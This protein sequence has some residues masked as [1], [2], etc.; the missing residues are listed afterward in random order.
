MTRHILIDN[1]GELHVTI[2]DW[3]AAVRPHAPGRVAI[4]TLGA[5][6]EW[7]GWVNDDSHPLGLPRNLVGGL[8]LTGLGAAVM[9]YAGPVIITGWTTHGTPTEVCD[10]TEAQIA[11]ILDCHTDARAA[12]AGEPGQLYD[13]AR[14]VAEQMRTAP[15][16]TITLLSG[17]EFFAQ[18][19]GQS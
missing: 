16:P 9:P 4:P 8:V 5:L 1:D 2:G 7:A 11:T 19:R 13:N 15:T 18:M 10:L 6:G 3:K 12:L 17:D 14:Q